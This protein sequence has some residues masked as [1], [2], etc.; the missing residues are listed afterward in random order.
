LALKTGKLLFFIVC[1]SD[2]NGWIVFNRDYFVVTA[3]N[4]SVVGISLEMEWT[5]RLILKIHLL[6]QTAA[7]RHVLQ[8][9]HRF[10]EE[11]PCTSLY[12]HLRKETAGSKNYY[13]KIKNI[14]LKNFKLKHLSV[15]I[16]DFPRER[17]DVTLLQKGTERK[18][19]E[20]ST[21]LRD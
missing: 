17:Q 12:T 16:C 5:A 9:Y 21:S 11:E 13:F 20:S 14:L 6:R 3:A 19:A 4:V 18:M 8:I 15:A 2:R 7:Q 1:R 10:V